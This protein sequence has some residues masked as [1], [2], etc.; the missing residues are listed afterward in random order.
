MDDD[1]DA[2]VGLASLSSSGIATIPSHK[3]KPRAP[4][5]DATASKRK[6]E[7]TPEEEQA[8]ES[9]KRKGQRHAT[10]A[11]DEAAVVATIAALVQREDTAARV[12]AATREA[13]LYLGLNPG[14]HGLINAVV[15]T[16]STG[17]S[18]F[19]RMVLPESPCASTI[20]PIPG[21]HIYP[22]ASRLSGECSSKVSVVAPSTPAPAPINLNATPVADGSSSGGPRKR[23]REM[24]LG[25]LSDASNLFDGMPTA[26]DDDWSNHFMQSIIFKGDAA[27]EG[28]LVSIDLDGFSLDHMF[29][30]DYDLEEEDE[31]D[32]D[33][34]PLL[35]GELI[36]QAAGVQPKRKSRR[37][38]AYTTAEDK[39]LCECWRDVGKYPKV[40]AKQKAF[41]VH[42]E[43]KSFSL[44]IIGGSPKMRRS[45]SSNMP[46][47]ERMGGRKPWR[48]LER[49]RSH[50]CA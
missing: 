17:S 30:D 32:I 44:L 21:F 45:S 40:G 10:D 27:V 34:E 15:T 5:K 41:K 19:P 3:G 42:H 4:R 8:R 37:T 7:M 14:Q 46:P 43:D 50:D 47:S 31:M 49:V 26:V 18:A 48:R 9:A 22:K 39:L 29:P 35:E 33:G 1:L 25:M 24:S 2:A 36:N 16:T 6:K 11:R 12:V 13:L 38:K 20:Q 28:D 23:A